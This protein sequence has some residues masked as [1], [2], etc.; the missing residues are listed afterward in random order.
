MI[1]TDGDD[2]ERIRLHLEDREGMGFQTIEQGRE[3]QNCLSQMKPGA[4]ILLDSITSLLMNELFTPENNYLPDETAASRV[5]A[6][7]KQLISGAANVVFV[8]DYLFS[9]AIR[10]D[11]STEAFR[12][13]LGLIHRELAA[14]CDTVVEV[15]SGQIILHKGVLPG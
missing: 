9:D 3:V 2:R 8:S 13:G 14:L 6:G 10:Y 7:L 15:A 4:T 12:S 11:S 5:L 1:P